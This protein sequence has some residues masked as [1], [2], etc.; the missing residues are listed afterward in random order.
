MVDAGCEHE[1]M[2]NV[3]EDQMI[4]HHFLAVGVLALLPGLAF[5]QADRPAESRFTGPRAGD[6]EAT[7]SGT[8]TNDNDFED[9]SFGVTGGYGYYWTDNV[10]LGVR[11][12]V[13]WVNSGDS[14]SVNGSTRFAID[15]LFN[16]GGRLRPFI[17]ANIGAIYGGNV[18]D[19]GTIGPEAGL[20]YFVNNTTFVL[21]QTEYRYHFDSGDDIADDFDDGSFVHTLGLGF[22][23]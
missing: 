2:R 13:N 18:T 1:A 14:N 6:H 20:K 19:T 5:A 21:A 4:R 15:Y 3:D 9:G 11:Q 22:T 7:L 17:G 16:A 8:G 23:F 12:S 10:Q